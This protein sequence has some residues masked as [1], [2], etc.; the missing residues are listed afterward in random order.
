MLIENYHH[1]PA[2]EEA[3]ERIAE[4]RSLLEAHLDQPEDWHGVIR[5]QVL[6]A[7]VHYSTAIEGNILT[8]DQVESIIAGEAIEVPEKDRIEALNY[9][10][11]MRWSQTRAQDPQWKLGH[12]TILTL[13][14]MVGT[15]L[16][17]GYEPLGQ[18]RHGQNTVQDRRTGEAIFWPPRPADVQDLMTEF[19]RWVRQRSDSPTNPYI[20]NALAHLNFVAVHPFSDGNGRVARLLCSLLM[21]REGYKAQAFWSL[22]QFFGENAEEYGRVISSALGPRWQPDRVDATAW[23]EWYLNAVATQVSTAE[24]AVRRSVAE[25]AAV[26]GA[27]SASGKLPVNPEMA[28]RTVIPVWL[29]VTG[30]RVTRRQLARYTDVSDETL[31]RDLRRL[32]QESLLERTGKGRGAAYLPG[33]TV[34]GWGSFDDLVEIALTGGIEA[35][36]DHFDGPE[37]RLF[38]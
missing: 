6:A 12:E 21:M 30:G 38:E 20:V 24:L 4:A 34:V 11:A 14:F 5:R 16:G 1:T 13:H 27:L 18:Y 7:V 17:S 15:D 28:P 22:E 32:S 37:L 10:R 36:M 31:S 33:P 2:M 9:Y 8:R 35:V 19:I 3:L 25:F 29:A 26:V 23:I